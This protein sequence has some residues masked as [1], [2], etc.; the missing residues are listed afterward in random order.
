MQLHEYAISVSLGRRTTGQ[1]LCCQVRFHLAGAAA[2]CYVGS[3]AGERLAAINH[4]TDGHRLG[5]S[6]ARCERC[7]MAA[8][9]FGPS[10]PCYHA[11]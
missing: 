9:R 8:K 6:R 7:T 2:L 11:H 3:L 1:Q 5:S 4:L 10:E